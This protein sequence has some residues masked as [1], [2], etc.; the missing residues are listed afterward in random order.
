MLDTC[1]GEKRCGA[2]LILLN[3]C[4]CRMPHQPPAAGGPAPSPLLAELGSLHTTPGRLCLPVQIKRYQQAKL[5]HPEAFILQQEE[6]ADVSSTAQHALF[7]AETAGRVTAVGTSGGAGTAVVATAAVC[8]PAMAI[9]GAIWW[10]LRQN[11]RVAHYSAAGRKPA[12]EVA[13]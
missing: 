5:W 4:P 9:C 10:W 1:V 2:Q 8:I 13:L 11:R 6:G 12:L 7:S 3:R